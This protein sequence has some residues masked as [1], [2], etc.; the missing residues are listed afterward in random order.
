[1]LSSI[2]A[3]LFRPISAL[4]LLPAI[5]LLFE[6]GRR[7]RAR[8][9]VAATSAA[10]EGAIF[11]LF[12]LLLAFTFSGAMTRYDAH[13]TLL[14]EE[15]NDIGKAYLRL[16]LLPPGSQPALRQ[17]FRDY[18][19]SRLHLFDSV[20]SAIAPDSIQLQRVI[21]EQSVRASAAPGANADATK[22]L[23]PAIN[24]MIDITATRQN[25]FHL[26]P[27]AM[28]FLLLF[29]LS[30]LCAFMAGSSVSEPGPNWF[31]AFALALTVTLTVYATLEIEH[32]DRGLIRLTQTDQSLVDLRNSM[33]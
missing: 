5:V 23:L 19:T 13:R 8:R 6:A 22:L 12:G 32:P 3:M 29:G 24:D 27:P 33:Q 1:L 4:I 31:Y 17:L 20:G 28:V 14:I 9:K 2:D 7:F 16:D 15:T 11:G 26:H 18:T 25:A 30:C 21:W 10:V